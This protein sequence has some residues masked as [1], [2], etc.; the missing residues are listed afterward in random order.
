MLLAW[1]QATSSIVL[2]GVTVAYVIFTSRLARSARGSEEAAVIA[3]RAALADVEIARL[4]NV[5]AVL[6]R[7]AASAARAAIT[8]ASSEPL[9]ERARRLVKM[10]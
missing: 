9:A 4:A 5:E 2:V 7:N 3:A 8:A 1:V 6:Q 10:T